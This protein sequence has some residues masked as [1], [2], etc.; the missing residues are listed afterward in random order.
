MQY[1][2]VMCHEPNLPLCRVPRISSYHCSL[3]IHVDMRLIP[4]RLHCSDFFHP[5]RIV[6]LPSLINV[7]R[8][9]VA[10][11]L[12][13]TESS[14]IVRNGMSLPSITGWFQECNFTCKVAAV[15][16]TLDPRPTSLNAFVFCGIASV[17]WTSEPSVECETSRRTPENTFQ[18]YTISVAL[19]SKKSISSVSVEKNFTCFSAFR[20][21]LTHLTLNTFAASLS[22]FVTLVD[23]SPNIISLKLYP[24]PPHSWG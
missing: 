17:V 16:S 14:V 10:R 23:Y 3:A 9:V 18:L 24:L 7:L 15:S 6:R 8:Q 5:K 20:E 21:T 19:P 12:E 22:A 11:L 4:A 1:K 2:L 13:T